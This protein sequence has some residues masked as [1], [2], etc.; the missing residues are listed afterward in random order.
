MD[1]YLCTWSLAAGE[2]SVIQILVKCQMQ[3]DKEHKQCTKKGNIGEN[4]WQFVNFEQKKKY[5]LVRERTENYCPEEQFFLTKKHFLLALIFQKTFAN[6]IELVND[7]N[8]NEFPNNVSKKCIA[9][10]I[11]HY[12]H[13]QW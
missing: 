9:H 8:I 3:E 11:S 10:H 7:F 6:D 5:S 4:L 12:H 2:T 1:L 13:Y